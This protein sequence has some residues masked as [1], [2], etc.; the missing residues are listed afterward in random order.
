M[1][2]YR[3]HTCGAL[4]ADHAGQEVRL[5]GWVHRKRDHG[6]LLFIDLRDQHGITQCVADSAS[7][8]FKVLEAIRPE[9]VI[10]VTGK[11]LPRSADTVNDKLPTG[12]IEMAVAA[13]EVLS[14]AAVL[15]M[16]VAGEQEYSEETRLI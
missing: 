7:A 14:E 2:S 1:H 4:R 11:V 3:T 12:A 10:C 15:P 6:H 5:S 9:S 8:V 13:V 16:Q